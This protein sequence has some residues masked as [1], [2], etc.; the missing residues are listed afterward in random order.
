MSEGR[1]YASIDKNDPPDCVA[2][3]ASGIRFVYLR[4]AFVE[5]GRPC[6]DPTPARDRDAWA[7][8]GVVVGG[9]VI[10]SYDPSGP[11]PEDQIQ[12]F[13]D[14]W[15]PRRSGELPPALDAETGS[16][17]HSSATDAQR[18][19]WLERAYDAMSAYYGFVTTY[20]SLDQ[21]NTNFGGGPSRVGNGGGWIKIPYPWKEHNPPHPESCPPTPGTLPAPWDDPS[22]PGAWITQYQGDAVHSTGFSSTVDCDRWILYVD[23]GRADVRTPWV[24]GQLAKLGY[25]S[26]EE[27][28]T[29]RGLVADKVVGPATFSVLT[30]V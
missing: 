8:A 6:A 2:A 14:T 4:G 28:Q 26:V 27:L 13:I 20:T 19:E 30:T 12:K 1:D 17:D 16:K 25:A 24:D 7:A 22:S 11:S 9:Y 18:K 5:Y 15:G 29:A 10:L 21:W 23:D 3:H